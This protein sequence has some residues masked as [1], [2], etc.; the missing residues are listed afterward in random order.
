MRTIFLFLFTLLSSHMALAAPA[1]YDAMAKI[2]NCS[3]SVIQ[4]EGQKDSDNVLLLT[5]GHCVSC[6]LSTT[7][8]IINQ[9]YSDVVTLYRGNTPLIV[10][11]LSIDQI[12]YATMTNTDLAI[13]RT[14]LS[15]QNLQDKLRLAPRKIS[16]Q[17]PEKNDA[18]SVTSGHLEQ[19]YR[20]QVDDII[21]AVRED[22]W[23]WHPAVRLKPSEACQIKPGASGAP[24]MNNEGKIVA[25]I[26]TGNQEGQSCTLNN[27]CEIDA[28][29]QISVNKG[30][31]YAVDTRML[32][33]CF[34]NGKLNL[35]EEC[36]LTKPQIHIIHTLP[37][38]D[39]EHHQPD[40]KGSNENQD[41]IQ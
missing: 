31:V 30:A 11:S 14:D 24:V 15:Y 12:V 41:V 38:P 39:P 1:A 36:P 16:N 40:D 9:P 8:A 20:C 23:Q 6:N 22:Q 5:N 7:D 35:S 28:S 27:P 10:G 21:N 34:P 18:V 26:N 3:A 2:R 37:L 32:N 29:G 25:L 13:L 17:L 4:F 33:A 19:H